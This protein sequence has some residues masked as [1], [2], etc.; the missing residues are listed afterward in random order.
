MGAE[1]NGYNTDELQT[2]NQVELQKIVELS[3]YFGATSNDVN[4]LEKVRI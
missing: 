2:L 3:P 4:W 1:V